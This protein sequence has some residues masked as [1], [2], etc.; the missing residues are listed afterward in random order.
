MTFPPEQCV[1]NKKPHFGTN[2]TCYVGSL[3]GSMIF[4][5]CSLPLPVGGF[6]QK[7]LETVFFSYFTTLCLVCFNTCPI[8]IIH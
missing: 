4:A 7:Q 5:S 2:E 8:H 6:S 3:M 1:P